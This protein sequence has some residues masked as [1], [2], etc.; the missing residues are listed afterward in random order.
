[1][2]QTISR[3]TKQFDSKIITRKHSQVEDGDGCVRCGG[4]LVEDQCYDLA[5]SGMLKLAINRCIQ[6]GDVID[7]VI[8][9][10][11]SL[12]ALS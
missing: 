10:H 1:M 6:C 8:L 9:E 11:R 3:I 7:S 5:G 4:M 12:H 2:A